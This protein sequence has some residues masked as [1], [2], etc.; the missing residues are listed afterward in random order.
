[1]KTEDELDDEVY[2]WAK[3][4]RASQMSDVIKFLYKKI[5]ILE[6]KL[7]NS[8]PTEEQMAKYPSLRDAYEQFSIIK[9][10]TTEN[11]KT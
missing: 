9:K 7:D 3:R 2:D 4:Q 10:L 6:E 11:D 5:M 8:I 1:M